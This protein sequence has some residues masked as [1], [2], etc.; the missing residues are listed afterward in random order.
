MQQWVFK[1]AVLGRILNARR[2][3]TTQKRMAET[4]KLTIKTIKANL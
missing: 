2:T 3:E 4:I 1:R